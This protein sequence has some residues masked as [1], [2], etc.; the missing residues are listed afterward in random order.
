MKALRCG[1]S[2]PAL[3]L[4]EADDTLTRDNWRVGPQVHPALCAVEVTESTP[5]PDYEVCPGC[6]DC[7]RYCADCVRVATKYS[8]RPL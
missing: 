3:H 8:E 6:A 1:R 2:V 5:V 4:V 7:V